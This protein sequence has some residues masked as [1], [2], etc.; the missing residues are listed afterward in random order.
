MESNESKCLPV[1][2]LREWNE[3]KGG[4]RHVDLQEG[5]LTFDGFIVIIPPRLLVG[6]SSLHD[7]IGRQVSI[8][9]SE[10]PDQIHVKEW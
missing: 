5:R 10:S 1:Y 2:Y 3:A 9:R 4:L 8:L 7:L 6:L